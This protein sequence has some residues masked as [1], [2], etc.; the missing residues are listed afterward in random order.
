MTEVEFLQFNDMTL[1]VSS[2]SN[3]I[4]GDASSNILIG[5]EN[6]DTLLGGAGDD[7]LDGGA[8][9]DRMVGGIGNDRYVVDDTGDLITGEIGYALGGGIDTVESFISYTL[10]SNLE[11]LRLQGTANINGTGGFAPEALVGNV[12]NNVL[13]GGGGNDVITAKAGDDTL[14]GGLGAD[15]LVGDAGADVFDFNNIN[16][17]R[18]GQASRDFINGFVRG[19]DLIDLSDIDANTTTTAAFTFLGSAAFSGTAGEL[20]YFSFGGGN[21]NIVEADVD[22]DG[23]ADMQIFVNLTNFMTGTDFIL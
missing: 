7:R 10:T 22:G 13:D 15:T 9:S 2:L 5:T 14:I 20:R 19:Q 16:Q 21:F 11:I 8:G 6:D 23:V 17:S 3:L 4:Q 1:A 12:G 18:P